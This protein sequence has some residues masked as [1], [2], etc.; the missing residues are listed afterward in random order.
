MGL[1]ISRT[2]LLTHDDIASCYPILSDRPTRCAPATGPHGPLRTHDTALLVF[3]VKSH[4]PCMQRV[5]SSERCAALL[6]AAAVATGATAPPSVSS[7]P[8]CCAESLKHARVS[9]AQRCPTD[10]S[11]TFGRHIWSPH[12]VATFDR[13]I[14]AAQRC[15]GKFLTPASPRQVA[16]FYAAVWPL[17][18]PPVLSFGGT[19][20]RSLQR[21]Q[22]RRCRRVARA[23][24][25]D[26]GDMTCTALSSP[27]LSITF[28][29]LAVL[30]RRHLMSE[31]EW[32]AL[33]IH[34]PRG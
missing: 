25:P 10:C 15:R 31:C 7:H 16:A 2:S 17:N 23:T 33:S 28:N 21:H 24:N 20:V 11:A 26:D 3:E 34:E 4:L 5:P 13:H 6:W 14:A 18:Q 12:L 9:P 29:P 30:R 8:L 19:S 27:P 22:W 32:D 1:G